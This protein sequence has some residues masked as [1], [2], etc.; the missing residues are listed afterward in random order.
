[1]GSGPVGVGV[2]GAGVIS[3]TYL[4]NMSRFSDLKVLFVADID[5]DRAR[6]QAEK[7]GVPRHGTTAELLE[8]EEIEIA[9]NLTIPVLHT[10]I[11]HEIVAAGKHVW[12][13]KPMANTVEECDRIIA[14]C[15]AAGVKLSVGYRLHFDPYHKEMMRLAKE[16]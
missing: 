13:E 15:K 4:E 12:S 3:G 6:A 16:K 7:Y 8:I 9:V 14:A 1:M 2:I 11:G 10:D 5:A